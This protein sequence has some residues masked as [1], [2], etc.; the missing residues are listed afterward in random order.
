MLHFTSAV[1]IDRENPYQLDKIRRTFVHAGVS[2]HYIVERDGTVRCYV[3]ENAVAW[4]AGEGTWMGD[5]KYTNK[6]NLYAIGIEILAIGSQ[7]DMA[8]Y[9]TPE[10][11]A[12][13][14]PALIGYTDEQYAS[15][16]KLVADICS[17]YEI[18]MTREYVLGHQ[19]YSPA[20]TDPGELFDWSRVLP[21]AEEMSG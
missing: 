11:Y 1:M 7:N 14:D 15:L 12:A 3:P 21:D 5:E 19:D 8:P 4:H 16:K 9:L 6:L 10:E 18:P 13:L 20:K 17:R 2:V